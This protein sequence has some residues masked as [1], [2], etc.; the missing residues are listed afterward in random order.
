LYTS[1]IEVA[2]GIRKPAWFLSEKYVEILKNN[3]NKFN[4]NFTGKANLKMSNVE[5]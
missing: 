2:R 5:N 4:M 3:F 1:F